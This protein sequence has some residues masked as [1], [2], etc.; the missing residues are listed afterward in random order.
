MKSTP[1]TL[2][3]E[4]DNSEFSDW[5]TGPSGYVSVTFAKQLERELCECKNYL[6]AF[7]RELNGDGNVVTAMMNLK[8]LQNE[9]E[10]VKSRLDKYED[11][12]PEYPPEVF[13]AH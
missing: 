4:I 13:K 1:R 8:R 3:A 5:G 6:D 12:C 2:V 7:V 10:Y 11:S 9:F